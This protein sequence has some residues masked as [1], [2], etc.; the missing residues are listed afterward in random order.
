M[1]GVSWSARGRLSMIVLMVLMG[2]AVEATPPGIAYHP[3]NSHCTDDEIKQCKN[4]PHV[5]PKFCPN[6]C[7]TECRSCKPICV[8]GPVAS[9]P[10]DSLPPPSQVPSPKPPTPSPPPSPK[11]QTPP[12]SPSPK[13]PTPSPPPSPKPQTP[14][15]SPSPKPPTLFPPP[16]PKPQTPSPSPSPKPPTPSPP[17]SPKPQTPPPSPSPKPPTLSPPPSPKPQTPSTSPS[18]KPPTPYPPSPKPQTPSPSPKPPT[19]SPP[20]SPKPQTPSPSPSPKPPTPYPPPSPKPQT[21]SP[22]PSPKPPTPS[23]SPKPPS[24]SPSPKPPTPSPP[25]SPKPQTP[26]PSPSPKPPTPYPP[27]PKPQTPSPS[28]S[29]KPPAPSPPPSPKPQ[30]PSPSPSPSP[31]PPTPSPPPY[32]KPQT[33]SPSSPPSPKPPTPPPPPP[34]YPKPQS[35]SPSPSQWPPT[36]STTSPKKVRC[37]L[38]KYP[39]C[40]AVEHQC[41]PACPG[42][43]QVDCVTCKPVCKCDMPGAVCQDPRFIGADG[44]TFYFHGKKDRDFCLVTDPNLHINAHFIGRRN[45]GMKRDFTWVQSIA[46]L[47][48]NHTIFIGAQKSAT[49]DDAVDRLSLSFDGEPILLPDT[50]S[51]TW[52]SNSAPAAKITRTADTNDVT[53]EIENTATITARVVPITQHE[54]RV[55]NYGITEED[56][57]AHLELGFKFL[58]LSSDEVDGVLGQTYRRDYVSR[59]KMGVAMPVIGGDKEF[60]SSSLFADDC[61]VSKFNGGRKGSSSSVLELPTMKCK[62][63]IY[64]RGVVCKR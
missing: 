56:C 11:P 14:P 4:L 34:P 32:P 60:A 44:L 58:S 2:M 15:P 53:L 3:S 23:P 24:P 62:S 42:G 45:H 16:S 49:W 19:P 52:L 41:P 38:S 47:Y 17:P 57:F 35:P 10:P 63:G 26:S 55:H 22:S 36:P 64:G 27:S 5:C 9:P 21:P 30:T 54:S 50:D 31:K 37:K 7:I 51:A 12:P 6:G 29:P 25:P 40:Y 18:P 28:P 48:N 8:D 33:P 20:P 61:A 43:C 59:V 1:A 46:I 39:S 13:P